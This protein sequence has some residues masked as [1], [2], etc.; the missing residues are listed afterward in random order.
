M[1]ERQLYRR[2]KELT[3]LSSNQ[4][5]QEIR[6]QT[7][8]DWFEANP[9]VT[10]KEVAHAV[11]FQRPSYFAQLFEQRYGINPTNLPHHNATVL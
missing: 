7:A 6:L 9:Y 3:G 8:R 10:L 4:F 5:I 11:G 2:V 1:S